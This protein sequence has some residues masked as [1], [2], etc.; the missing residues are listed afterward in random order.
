MKEATTFL[1]QPAH[2]TPYT[3]SEFS[4]PIVKSVAAQKARISKAV[5]NHTH[6]HQSV[7]VKPNLD[8]YFSSI[9][10]E[11]SSVEEILRSRVAASPDC[12]P[13]AE[14][15]FF[16]GDLGE[17]AR[18]H[19][20]WRTKLPRIEPFY[21]V[22]CNPD[23][24]VVQTLVALGTG[25]DCASKAEIQMVLDFGVDP[26]KVIYANPCKQA[27]H[28][29]YAA[30]RGVTMMT[31]DN[32]D[33]LR[34]IKQ[35]MPNAQLVIRILTDDSKSLC[36]LGLKFGAPLDTVPFLLKTAQELDLDVIG[37]SFHVGSGC[38]DANAFGE[39]VCNA[40]KVIEEAKNYGFEMSMLDV[41]GGFPG[42]G[43]PGLTFESIVNVLGPAVD[44]YIPS[45]IR[46]IA[47]PGRYFVASAYTLAVNVVARRVVPRDN[48]KAA[49][50][51]ASST[52]ACDDMSPASDMTLDGETVS[53]Q[54]SADDHPAYM[55]EK[56]TNHLHCLRPRSETTDY[57][58]DGM[59]GSFNCITFDHQVVFANVL[60]KDGKFYHGKNNKPHGEIE[61]SCSIWGPTCD[62]FDCITR[63]TILPEMNVGD[64]MYFENM[65]A[66]TMSAASQFN[67]FRKSPIIY[68]NT[69][70][71]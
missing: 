53:G 34:K 39:A 46:V 33:E 12:D 56:E 50:S 63:E 35:W 32:A 66:Y 25:F 10:T 15:A 24:N 3:T 18:Q 38:F 41:G 64:W 17:V 60:V 47:E 49:A 19:L 1:N 52:T 11:T 61:Y 5:N 51:P 70:N 26:S 40:G 43:G 44:K 59:Y 71:L 68:T 13:E 4:G 30:S 21:A 54:P 14:D 58:N 20:Q 23:P 42:N 45:H 16:V 8:G 31:F 65:G 27:S 9:C 57:I 7:V 2:A 29:R 48:E 6:N 55:S 37:V 28:I 36:K 62:S 67:G 22:K 69:F